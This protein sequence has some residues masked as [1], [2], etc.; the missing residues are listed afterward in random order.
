MDPATRKTPSPLGYYLLQEMLGAGFRKVAPFAAVA[1]I[2]GSTMHRIIYGDSG[3]PDPDTLLKIA[4][5]L[6]GPAPNGQAGDVERA[7]YERVVEARH[8]ELLAEAGYRV[9][10]RVTDPTAL[11]IDKLLGPASNL[12]P[13]DRDLLRTMIDRLVDS[14]L[15]QGR[16]DAG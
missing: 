7:D 1:D 9:G 16:R 2:S 13:E 11:K 4:R 12:P 3:R 5:A 8:Q 15:H 10:S 6:V 14:F